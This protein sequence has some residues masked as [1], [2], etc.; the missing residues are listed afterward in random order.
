MN[1]KE[2]LILLFQR[3]AELAKTEG[4][5]PRAFED[6]EYGE[7]C[8]AYLIELD[9]ETDGEKLWPTVEAIRGEVS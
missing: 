5:T 2:R 4:Y 6:A 3:W 1:P 7:D 9:A 8:A